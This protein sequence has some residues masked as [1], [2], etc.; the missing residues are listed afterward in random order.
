MIDAPTI[1]DKVA[2]LERTIASLDQRVAEIK[3]VLLR[4]A[5]RGYTDQVIEGKSRAAPIRGTMRT[6]I[7]LLKD[8]E[9]YPSLV[10]PQDDDAALID[11]ENELNTLADESMYTC[12]IFST[13]NVTRFDPRF[14]LPSYIQGMNL[15]VSSLARWFPS[16]LGEPRIRDVIL[17]HAARLE[18]FVGVIKSQI[19]CTAEAF[20]AQEPRRVPGT[21]LT[22]YVELLVVR[23]AEMC[24]ADGF[25]NRR[26]PTN[27][28][29]HFEPRI[30]GPFSVRVYNELRKERWTEAER[31]QMFQ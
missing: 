16:R 10:R 14:T 7:S 17:F 25:M 8:G 31:N 27:W 1:E 4:E 21:Q 28:Q 30:P 3:R 9:R 23:N 18:Y 20:T 11:M 24:K 26:I 22:H 2:V 29:L 19:V 15:Y 6:L 13:A 12:T 5:F